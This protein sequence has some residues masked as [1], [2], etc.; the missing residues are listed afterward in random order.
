M[1]TLQNTPNHAGVKI[2]GDYFDLEELNKAIY[3][4]IG[5]ENKYLHYTGSRTRILGICHAVRQAALGERNVETVFNG[6]TD[7]AKKQKSFISPDKNIYFSTEVLWPEILYAAVAL[8][9]FVRLHREDAAFPDWEPEVHVITH[10][11]S[12]VL[13]C[14]HGQVPEAEY[15]VIMK[16]FSDTAPVR[17]YAV[18]YI[19]FLNL[20][21]IDMAKQQREN[22]LS[23]VAMKIATQDSDY[24]AFR[25]QVLA[26][27]TPSKKAIHEIQFKADYPEKIDW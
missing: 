15:Q 12:L 17:D 22:A 13:D 7:H 8:K 16:T 24:N 25:Q 14:L 6:L 21:Y 27:A 2:S 19:D 18:Q 3:H 1:L 5:D 23:S 26:A 10:F 11:Q 4:V 9:D 20:K